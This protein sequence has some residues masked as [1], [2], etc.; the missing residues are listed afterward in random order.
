M[1]TAWHQDGLT[2]EEMALLVVLAPMARDENPEFDDLLETRIT[3]SGVVSLPLAGDVNIWVIRDRL[4][5]SDV[6]NVAT[7]GRALSF[8]EDLFGLPFPVTDVV[9]VVNDRRTGSTDA[10]GFLGFIGLNYGSHI[11][12]TRIDQQSDEEWTRIINH[13]TSHYHKYEGRWFDE[14]VSRL[15]ETLAGEHQGTTTVAAD[16]AAARERAENCL[17]DGL[18]NL[19]HSLYVDPALWFYGISRCT[20][21]LGTDLIFRLHDAMGKDALV[22]ALRDARIEPGEHAASGMETEQKIYNSLR[23][24]VPE[25]RVENFEEIYNLY[26]GG[27]PKM[28]PRDDHGDGIED[29][30]LLRLAQSEQGRLDYYFDHDYFR[31]VSK[32]HQIYQID[33]EFEGIPSS[34]V[35]V[36]SENGEAAPWKSREK[37]P[38]GVRLQWVSPGNG[39]HYIGI[40][41]FSGLTGPYSVRITELVQEADD[42]SN[43]YENATVV[44]P[45][46]LVDGNAEGGWVEGVIDDA[47]DVDFFKFRAKRGDSFA[48]QMDY[49]ATEVMKD[50]GLP[51]CVS[52]WSLRST[53]IIAENGGLIFDAVVD[54]WQYFAAVGFGSSTGYYALQVLKYE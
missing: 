37:T 6:D 20:Y 29:A 48:V 30:A 22:E 2:P 3:S 33:I 26:Y 13:E 12:G 11:L 38:A 17:D 52:Y 43:T 8:L 18:V 46:A 25:G 54:G 1:D 15:V 9:M 7:I 31:F 42:H 32:E 35:L 40:H 24:N 21:D 39:P 28:G 44:E 5:D 4:H 51:C 50:N 27:I 16:A 49:D 10:Q 41:G 19:R 45:G 47:T 23:A 53:S 36:Y 14:A 34:H